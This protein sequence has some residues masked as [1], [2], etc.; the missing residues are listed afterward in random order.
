MVWVWQDPVRAFPMIT[1]DEVAASKITPPA[2]AD[3][4]P[5]DWSVTI[6]LT[7]PTPLPEI[8]DG[9]TGVMN[10]A[11]AAPGAANRTAA[12]AMPAPVMNRTNPLI[13]N[14]S[15]TMTVH[16]FHLG[17]PLAAPARSTG[18]PQELCP[19]GRWRR[20]PRAGPA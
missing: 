7:A 2:S 19:P 15:G 10:A 18:R 9:P 16:S 1:S 12:V 4:E 8:V 14:S 3:D 5:G 11:E 20:R 13:T 17:R 6:V